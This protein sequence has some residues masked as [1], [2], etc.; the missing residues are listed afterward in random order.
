MLMRVL[1]LSFIAG[2]QLNKIFVQSKQE[3]VLPPVLYI[4]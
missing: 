2:L 4:I 1:L 3:K